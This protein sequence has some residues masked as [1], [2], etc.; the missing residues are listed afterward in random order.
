MITIQHKQSYENPRYKNV[1]CNFRKTDVFHVIT[2]F[3]Q[4]I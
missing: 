2:Y 1:D 3:A 4:M